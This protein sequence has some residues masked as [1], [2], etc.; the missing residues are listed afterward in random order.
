MIQKESYNFL[1]KNTERLKMKKLLKNINVISITSLTTILLFTIIPKLF[2]Y[3]FSYTTNIKYDFEAMSAWGTLLSA[4]IPL[5]LVIASH[6]VT[7]RVDESNEITQREIQ[8]SN[9]ITADYVRIMIDEAIKS[10]PYVVEQTGEMLKE[11]LKE[12]AYKYV[13]LQGICNTKRVAD[14]LNISEDEAFDILEELFKIDGLIGAGGRVS[15]ENK[16]VVW[17]KKKR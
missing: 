14:H 16:S 8:E 13:S 12:K 5:I 11:K 6:I 10:N 15:K 3:G 7:K 2:G 17:T 9:A 1:I 4:F